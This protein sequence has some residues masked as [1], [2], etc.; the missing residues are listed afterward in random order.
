M[1]KNLKNNAF[2]KILLK[3]S[4]CFGIIALFICYIFLKN[5]MS[6]IWTEVDG[7]NQHFITL[8]YFKDIFYNLI[9]YHNFNTFTWNIGF[10]LDMFGNLAY[11]ILGD[12]FSY[13]SIFVPSQY[14]KYLY[15]ILVPIRLYFVG[16]SFL[17]YCKYRNK[18]NTSA[19]IGSLMYT[20]CGFAL[21]SSVR[22]HYFINAMIVFPISMIGIEKYILENKKILYIFSVFLMFF[23][24][25]YFGYMNALVIAVYGIILWLNKYKG[26]YKKNVSKLFMALVYALVGVMMCSFIL[27]P[28]IYQFLNSSRTDVV[29]DISYSISYYRNLISSITTSG[30]GLN[31]SIISISAIILFTIPIIIRNRKKNIEL[32]ALMIVLFIPLLF[33][34]CSYIISGMSYPSNRYVYM[35]MF[36]LSF[37]TVLVLNKKIVIDIKCYLIMLILYLFLLIIFDTGINASLLGSLIILFLIILVYLYK[38]KFVFKFKCYVLEVVN[39]IVLVGIMFN[40]YYLYDVNY[41]NYVSQFMEFYDLDYS[42]NTVNRDINHF[43]LALDY[44]KESDK[45]FYKISKSS[46]DLWNLGLLK[47]YNSINYF[48]SINSNLYKELA[49][50]LNNS[51]SSTSTDIKEFDN[52]SKITSLLGVKYYISSDKNLDIYGYELVKEYDDTYVYK[53]KYNT[54]FANMYTKCI[55]KKDYD[56]L[57]SLEKEDALLKYYISDNCN[58]SDIYLSDINKLEYDSNIKFKK[59]ITID[60]NMGNKIKLSPKDKVKGELYLKIDNISYKEFSLEKEANDLYTREVDKNRFLAMNKFHVEDNGFIIK[61]STDTY[62]NEEEV[63]DDGYAY[64]SGNDDILINLG[65]YDNYDG[66]IE[67][68]FS[69]NG[70][71]KFD[72]IEL[73]SV[74]M[75]DYKEDINNLNKSNFKLN[76]YGNN[77]I[78][79][80]VNIDEDGVIS[81]ATLYNKGWTL[82][83]D[84][85]KV[86]TFKNE[87]FLAINM[88]KG[89]HKIELVYNT[90]YLKEGILLSIIGVMCY[91]IVIIKGILIRKK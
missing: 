37:E 11:Y 48:Y 73:Y 82:K 6:F 44:I 79:G 56:K 21:Y 23:C 60:N 86:N 27:F 88:N 9:K 26:N 78:N 13:V 1:I 52:R 63:Y 89:K 42:Y 17:C 16:V 91:L 10:G 46:N 14:L 28:T 30:A 53:N 62:S 38:D 29:S 80:E 64:Y 31:W 32:F 22:H 61:A 70:E 4:L 34:S 55:N 5:H 35:L 85:K 81:F 19:I 36:V 69:R 67:I 71:Y 49:D 12:L 77:Y 59:K 68:E 43:Y 39:V 76:S 8:N 3:Y 24:S 58:N 40:A 66:D 57:N 2:F 47:N 18:V 33:S 50:D 87:Y 41:A 75:D 25:F 65:Y 84:G 90:L 54:Q 74:S 15:F 72:N 20:F 7:L 83:A 45:E 51:E